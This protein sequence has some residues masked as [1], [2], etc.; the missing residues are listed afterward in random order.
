M[1]ERLRFAVGVGRFVQ[2]RTF[3]SIFRIAFVALRMRTGRADV[4]GARIPAIAIAEQPRAVA[5][6]PVVSGELGVK[7]VPLGGGRGVKIT[8]LLIIIEIVFEHGIK[9]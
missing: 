9:C 6:A 3:R 7:P 2:A 8:I 1:A 5:V 4:E